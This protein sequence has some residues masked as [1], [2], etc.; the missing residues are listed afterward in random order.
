M[1]LCFEFRN[2]IYLESSANQKETVKLIQMKLSCRKAWDQRLIRLYKKSENRKEPEN[3][4]SVV[5]S[6]LYY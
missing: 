5:C 3:L 4:H 1:K 2:I 6:K